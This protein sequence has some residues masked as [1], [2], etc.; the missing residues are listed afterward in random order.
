MARVREQTNLRLRL[1]DVLNSNVITEREWA[2][3]DRHPGGRRLGN[4]PESFRVIDEALRRVLDQHP[5]RA[6][7]VGGGW[8]SKT[9]IHGNLTDSIRKSGS[10]TRAERMIA[11]IKDVRLTFPEML[12]EYFA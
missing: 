9:N 10:Y 12:L 1:T 2:D 8:R 7:Y 4:G 6:V 11:Q 3:W 5:Y